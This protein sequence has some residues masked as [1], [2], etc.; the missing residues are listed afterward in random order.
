MT[1]LEPGAARTLAVVV[2]VGAAGVMPAFLV[3]ALSLQVRRDLDMGVTG[4]GV[5][6][7][8]FFVAAAV[9]SRPLGRLAER[10]GPSVAMRACGLGAAVCLFAIG[11]LARSPAALLGLLAMAG[12]CNAIS[13]PATNLFLTRRTRAVQQGLLFGIKQSAIPLAI[14][15]SGLAVPVA[16]LS[17]GW[18]PT[19]AVAGLLALAAAAAVPREADAIVER[20]R[21]APGGRLDARLLGMLALGVGLSSLGP[22]A[23]PAHLVASGAEAGISEASSGLVLAAGSLLSLVVRVFAGWMADRRGRHDFTPVAALLALGSIGFALTASGRPGPLVIGALIAFGLGW[24]WNGLFHFAV[25]NSNRDAPAA[26]TGVTQSGIYAGAALGPALFGLIA[27]EV[28]F[29][30]A[31]ATSATF[32]LTA[33]IVILFVARR[34]TRAEAAYATQHG[35]TAS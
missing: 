3:G 31:W 12:I 5:A 33:A 10:I 7:A 27:G 23:L 14:L 29:A 11:G 6:V 15:V 21:G 26:A 32:M 34:A 25:V 18:R 30:A 24:G 2:A 4:I 22:N 8:I 28:S 35:S 1:A 9:G 19:F 20:P 16:A 13:Q 17:I